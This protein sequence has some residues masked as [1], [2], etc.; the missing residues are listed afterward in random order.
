[1]LQQRRENPWIANGRVE[2]L[3]KKIAIRKKK[4]DDDAA[5]WFRS[6][7]F[8]KFILIS[9]HGELQLRLKDEEKDMGIPYR[10]EV[11]R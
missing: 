9:W 5:S 7:V 2:N 1:M 8:V 6:Y 3:K 4:N 10:R 11:K